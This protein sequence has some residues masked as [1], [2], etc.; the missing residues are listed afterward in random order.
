MYG[1]GRQI[2]LEGCLFNILMTYSLNSFSCL[3]KSCTQNIFFFSEKDSKLSK[4]VWESNELDLIIYLQ[5]GSCRGNLPVQVG[6]PPSFVA[7]SA[8]YGDPLSR[9]HISST[10]KE[11]RSK[12][13]GS[14]LVHGFLCGRF[15][16]RVSICDPKSSGCFD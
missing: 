10:F 2:V 4:R 16:V 14:R 9:D 3:K 13:Q 5:T 6:K 12:V 11:P 7:L 8:G 1:P 15:R